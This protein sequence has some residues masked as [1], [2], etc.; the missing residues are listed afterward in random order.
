M[1]ISLKPRR[2][3]V[4][5]CKINANARTLKNCYATQL[6]WIDV[7]FTQTTM[8]GHRPTYI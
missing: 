2:H 7:F 4:A 1:E 8:A 3:V 5:L 6:T